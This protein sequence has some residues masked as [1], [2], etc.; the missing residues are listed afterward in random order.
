ME[1]ERGII[2]ANAENEMKGDNHRLEII[3]TQIY[4]YIYIYIY[5]YIYIFIYI[6][7]YIYI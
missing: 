5:R 4:I 1:R 6:Y 3:A 2:M 7:I